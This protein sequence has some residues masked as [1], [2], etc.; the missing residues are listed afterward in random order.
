M[1]PA[2]GVLFVVR[3]GRTDGNEHRYVGWEDVA[4]NAVGREQAQAVAD[5]L[6]DE[7]VDVI[8][9]SSLSRAVET[10]RPLAERH[11]APL[12]V[13]DELREIHYGDLQGTLKADRALKLRRNHLRERMPGGESLHD[14]FLRVQRV[15][16]E[17][18]TD[19]RAGRNVATVAHF[20]SNRMLVGLLVGA[21]FDDLF[22]RSDYTPENGSVWRMALTGGD[23]ALRVAEARWA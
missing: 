9:V 13:R 14:V 17:V 10:A 7:T 22:E 11:G 6:G 23:G 4:L 5:R 19:L 12:R 2:P 21:S 8:Y 15:H 1:S 3:H 20:W 18:E 16:A